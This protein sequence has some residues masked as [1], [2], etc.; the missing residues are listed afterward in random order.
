[1]LRRGLNRDAAGRPKKPLTLRDAAARYAGS[2]RTSI[3]RIVKR[4]E[5]AD[6]VDYEDVADPKMGPP[7]ATY[8]G[9]RRS[10]CVLYHLDAGDR[11]CS[12][13]SDA[14]P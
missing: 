1:R 3:G 13:H 9:R 4:L 14:P 2:A 10:Y 12:T 11:G 7:A 5:A 8:G 6:T